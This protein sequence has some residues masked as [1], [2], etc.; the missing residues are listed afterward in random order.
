MKAFVPEKHAR[1]EQRD[2]EHRQELL[3]NNMKRL[4]FERRLSSFLH[5]NWWGRRKD[6]CIFFLTF[7]KPMDCEEVVRRIENAFSDVVQKA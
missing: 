6:S 2:R 7:E 4:A 5:I 1:K 3:V